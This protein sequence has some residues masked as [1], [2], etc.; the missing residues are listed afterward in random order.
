MPKVC[1][2]CSQDINDPCFGV[3]IYFTIPINSSII[4][5]DTVRVITPST[6]T[7]T[8]LIEISPF[9]NLNASGDIFYQFNVILSSVETANFVIYRRADDSQWV[10]GRRLDPTSITYIEYATAVWNEGDDCI[11]SHALTWTLNTTF[12]IGAQ[13][14]FVVPGFN[15]SNVEQAVLPTPSENLNICDPPVNVPIDVNSKEYTAVRINDL[16]KCLISK[17]TDYLNKLKGGVA[18][19]NLELVKLGLI[20]ELLKKK[21]CETALPCLYNRRDFPTTLYKGDS[22]SDLNYISGDR[23]TLSG[24]FIGYAGANFNVTCGGTFPDVDYIT[25]DAVCD[26]CPAGYVREV[27]NSQEICVQSTN[28]AA[29]TTPVSPSTAAISVGNTY[30]EYNVRGLNLTEDVT[31][32]LNALQLT[33]AG[34]A[35]GN[36]NLRTTSN[37]NIQGDSGT[38]LLNNISYRN[39]SKQVG[40]IQ[41]VQANNPLF[42]TRT[43]WTTTNGSYGMLNYSGIWLDN[44][45]ADCAFNTVTQCDSAGD[46]IEI[47]KCLVIP[48]SQTTRTYLFGMAAEGAI[49]IEIRG[50][51]F[52]NGTSF[53]EFI[54]FSTNNAAHTDTSQW[55]TVVPVTLQSGNY[56][57]RIRAYNYGV[58]SA[59]AVSLDIYN[60]SIGQFKRSFCNTNLPAYSSNLAMQNILQSAV[61]STAFPVGNIVNPANLAVKRA[62]LWT[63]KIFSLRDSIGQTIYTQ[64][65]TYDCLLGGELDY[66]NNP[67]TATCRNI[68]DTIPY[69]YCCDREGCL[70]NLEGFSSEIMDVIYD[71]A[72]DLSTLLLT[73][74]IPQEAIGNGNTCINYCI[75]YSPTSE[76][77]L[78]TFVNYISKECRNCVTTSTKFSTSSPLVDAVPERASEAVT[79]NTGENITL[80]NGSNIT[81]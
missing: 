47:Y 67:V 12:T 43:N 69:Y 9:V 78:E 28:G 31:N 65:V 21:D 20:I 60:I 80:E 40:Q 5:T 39:Y 42:S 58:G 51:G 70:E 37:L 2:T 53:V 19:S 75:S 34:T 25:P 41:N 26:A 17:G 73:D 45:T 38:I 56:T 1:L 44:S 3:L 77:Y 49:K 55:Y 79:T 27:V 18:C 50:P 66:C 57:F 81:L 71:P 74:P 8:G 46:Y 22:C 64:P 11:F 6:V 15:I 4:E 59:S 61:G 30:F 24:N 48:N 35:N 62:E 14:Y 63:Y 72:T 29:S 32:N 54:R 13:T 23:I 10:V 33:L 36:Y 7:T 76:T 16:D 52:G 68:T